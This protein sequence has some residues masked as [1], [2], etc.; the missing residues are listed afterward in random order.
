MDTTRLKDI[1]SGLRRNDAKKIE[2]DKHALKGKANILRLDENCF[3]PFDDGS[4]YALGEDGGVMPPKFESR[5]NFISKIQGCIATLPDGTKAPGF[6]VNLDLSR[7]WTLVHASETGE[8]TNAVPLINGRFA[9]PISPDYSAEAYAVMDSSLTK[10]AASAKL[11][12]DSQNIRVPLKITDEKDC[13]GIFIVVRA[14]ND[15]KSKFLPIDSDSDW[16]RKQHLYVYLR[17]QSLDDSLFYLL[18][19]QE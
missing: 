5:N 9:V 19:K 11:N 6:Y 7:N 18:L 3:V 2:E 17:F 16:E 4:G 10:L 13:L 1:A 14:K 15:G 12:S 8:K